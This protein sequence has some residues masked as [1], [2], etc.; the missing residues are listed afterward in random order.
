[1]NRLLGADDSLEMSSLIFS[2]KKKKKKKYLRMSSAANLHG[3]LRGNI[4]VMRQWMRK[5][6]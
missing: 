2:E 6:N 3:A 1:M 4:M 5:V